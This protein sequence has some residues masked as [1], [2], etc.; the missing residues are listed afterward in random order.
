M[1]SPDQI[2]RTYSPEELRMLAAEGKLKIDG[3]DLVAFHERHREYFKFYTAV[4]RVRNLRQLKRIYREI[5]LALQDEISFAGRE[6]IAQAAPQA[7]RLFTGD[8]EED[9]KE[10]VAAPPG[11]LKYARKELGKLG[12]L[13]NDFVLEGTLTDRVQ[14]IQNEI[15]KL[16]QVVIGT[17]QILCA[18][19]KDVSIIYRSWP[20]N[21]C[22]TG[23][24][25]Q[26][27]CPDGSFYKIISDGLWKGYFTLVELRNRNTR[28]LLLDVLNFSGLKM[29]NENFIK[30]LMHQIIQTAQKNGF[31]YVLTNPTD[32]HISNRDYIRRTFHKAFPSLGLVQNFS[33]VNTPTARFQSLNPNQSIAWQSP[34]IEN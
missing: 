31:D 17:S 20:G 34:N 30:L 14:T 13:M 8:S 22:N 28:G 16:R 18:P 2:I 23:D 12:K 29:E 3:A 15:T 27:M 32:I 24:L 25:K 9:Q 4:L 7:K 26:I 11:Y 5:Y 10:R 21:D 6:H 1:P 33:L 19:S